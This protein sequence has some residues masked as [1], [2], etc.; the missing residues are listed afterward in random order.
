MV[1]MNAFY[2]LVAFSLMWV[3]YVGLSRSRRGERDF[4][5]IFQG[6]I[7]QLTRRLRI[8][9]QQNFVERSA[10]GWRPSVVAITRHGERLGHFDLLRW[11]SHRHGFGHFIQYVEGDYS[12]TT[13]RQ[14]RT[15]VRTLIGQTEA[16]GAGVYVDSLVSPSFPLALTQSLQMP[17]ISGT[18]EQLSAAGIRRAAARGNRGERRG[19]PGRSGHRVQRPHP[20]LHQPPVRATARPSTSG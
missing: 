1:R 11:I 14:A 7:F 13:A 17:G 12:R 4:A 15:E 18:A 16:S 2:A 3:M 8:T 20:P 9:L 6:T 5:A 19:R 10:G